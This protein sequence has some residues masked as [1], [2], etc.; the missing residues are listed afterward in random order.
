MEAVLLQRRF[1]ALPWIRRQAALAA[2]RIKALAANRCVRLAGFCGLL[3]GVAPAGAAALSSKL[4]WTLGMST[5]AALVLG[6]LRLLF[7]APYLRQPLRSLPLQSPAAG[8]AVIAGSYNPPHQGHL[9]VIRHL[10]RIHERVH[11]VI[12]VNPGKTYAVSPYV[13]QELLRA[14]LRE[15][16]LKNVEVVIWSSYVWKHAQAVGASVMYRGIRS[17]RQDGLAEKWLELQNL[18]AQ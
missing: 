3:G 14:M 9:E 17:W 2:L 12:G 18:L 15:L 6:A 13:R 1:Q 16:E 10:S 5:L 8:L 11:V 4:A 7:G